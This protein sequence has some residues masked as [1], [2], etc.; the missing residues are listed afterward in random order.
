MDLYHSIAELQALEN[1]FANL[2][3]Q[4][5]L[6]SIVGSMQQIPIKTLIVKIRQRKDVHKCTQCA[7]SKFT[8]LAVENHV[9]NTHGIEECYCRFCDYIS[10]NKHCLYYHCNTKHGVNIYGMKLSVLIRL[11]LV[12]QT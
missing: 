3:K 1:K 9:Y 10:G 4:E 8:P 7:Y 5:D 6:C 11:C 12:L 2:A